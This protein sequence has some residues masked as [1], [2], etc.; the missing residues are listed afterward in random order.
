MVALLLLALLAVPDEPLTI[1]R[2][3]AR[4]DIHDFAAGLRE[5]FAYLTLRR[6]DLAD[7]A[8][9][10]TEDLPPRVDV[11]E[12]SRTLHRLLMTA[13]DGH[14]RVRPP[15]PDPNRGPGH[16]PV[17]LQDTRDGVFALL[18]DRSA[19]L[20]PDH[21]RVLALDGE[22]LEDWIEATLPDIPQGTAWMRRSRALATL[23][24][25]GERRRLRDLPP[26]DTVVLTL[27]S[28]DGAATVER[29]LALAPLR[30]DPGVWPEHPSGRLDDGLAYLR[31]ARM[32]SAAAAHVHEV[33]PRFLDAP[34]LIV[35]VRGNGGGSREALLALAGYLIGDDQGPWVGNLAVYK[36]A[37]DF[38]LDHLAARF[39]H[40][41]DWPGWTA[42]QRA[43]VERALETFEPEWDPGPGFSPWHALVLDRTGHPAEAP[44]PGRVVVLSDPLCYSATDIFLAAL[45]QHP[46]VTLMGQASGGG[47]ARSQSFTLPRTGIRV[48]CASMASFQPDGRLFDGR[49]V[50]MDVELVPTP[51]DALRG[52]GDSVL[53]RARR[54]LLREQ[55]R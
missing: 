47:S 6:D 20:D 4:Q 52:G 45:G 51:E 10:L 15:S 29:E 50:A 11:H 44:Y 32:D 14:A 54:F 25:L 7:A 24:F 19:W 8:D 16:L 2:D 9:A 30:P 42:E 34:G 46:R 5:R 23:E 36:R 3:R 27:A 12:L 18:P 33:M 28:R 41:V 48:R 38:G 55:G 53:V 26:A 31:L 17:V 43:A 39:M 21:P 22:P 1:D 13:G 40:P 49:G 35:D 37:R